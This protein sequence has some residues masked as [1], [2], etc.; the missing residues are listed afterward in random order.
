M[1][2]QTIRIGSAVDIYQ[3]DDGA[4]ASGIECSAPISAASPVNP[5]DCLTLGDVGTLILGDV[6]SDATPQLGGNLDLNGYNIEHVAVL[7]VNGTYQGE[8]ITVTV[9]DASAAFGTP[10]YCATDFHFERADADASGTMHCEAV[11]LEAG[12]GSKKVL[13]NGQICN[14]AWNWVSGPVYISCTTGEFV[15]TAPTG[16]GDQVQRVGF[17]LSPDTIYFSP[18]NT[19]I[20][21]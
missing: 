14:T 8:I 21:I 11:A 10:L 3:Y 18:D 6:A 19:V 9:D 13:L 15:Q 7:T 2:L 1:A 5:N 12:A 17:A 20:E 16:I 4:Y